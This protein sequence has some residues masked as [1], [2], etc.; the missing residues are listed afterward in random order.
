MKKETKQVKDSKNTFED[1][2]LSS[3]AKIKPGQDEHN[4]ELVGEV[5]GVAYVN[6]AKCVNVQGLCEAIDSIEAPVLLI[7]GGHDLNNDYSPLAEFK[8]KKLKAIIY[9]GSKEE[10]I[11]KSYKNDNAMFV[12]SIN[13]E[14]AVKVAYWFAKKGDAVLYSPACPSNALDSYR[15]R[16]E[17][18]KEVVNRL[19]G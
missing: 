16:G 2:L 6:D 9:L 4:M 11:L 15:T 19:R 7:V 13:I 1:K 18:Y 8:R 10:T 17:E 3:R 12:T 14:E 5:K